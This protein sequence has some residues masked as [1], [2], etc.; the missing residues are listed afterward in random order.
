M[1]LLMTAVVGPEAKTTSLKTMERAVSG[2][3]LCKLFGTS[4]IFHNT[5]S[6][7]IHHEYENI[8]PSSVKL[9]T[10]HKQLTDYEDVALF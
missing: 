10:V 9:L 6:H 5:S 1:L 8:D 7:L 4:D 3:I 2:I